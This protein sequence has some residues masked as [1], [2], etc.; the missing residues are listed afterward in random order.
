M[1]DVGGET[2]EGRQRVIRVFEFLRSLH[3]HRYPAKRR[4]SEQLWSLWLERLPSHP[5][6]AGPS[7]FGLGR[8]GWA[9]S[10]ETVVHQAMAMLPEI[11]SCISK[12]SS[13]V[14]P[15]FSAQR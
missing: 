10:E 5:S 7:A 11:R 2:R 8:D 14:P 6:V 9:G 3:E 1:R 12:T 13:I 4:V 15:Y